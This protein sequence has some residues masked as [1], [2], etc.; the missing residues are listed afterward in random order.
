MASSPPEPLDPTGILLS[1]AN[2]DEKAAEQLTPL[3]YTELRRIAGRFMR[4]ERQGH[5]LQPTA[6]VHEAYMA[7]IDVDRVQWNG[8]SHFVAMAARVMRRV[9]IDHARGHNAE[10]RGGGATHVELGDSQLTSGVDLVDVLDLE[11]ALAE[12]AELDERQAK[13]VELRFFGGLT[14]EETAA[15]C[16]VSR[17][18]VKL[19]WRMAR[20]WLNCRLEEK[21][22][23]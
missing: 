22:P 9:L 1:A 20:A 13:V 10:K 18:T 14:L 21:K 6:V 16:G 12:L 8:R 11:E 15:V 3:V 2:G 4:D 5:S 17:D 19:D 7:L 23:K